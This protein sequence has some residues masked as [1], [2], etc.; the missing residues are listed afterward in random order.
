MGNFDKE[1]E[2]L[3]FQKVNN[4]KLYQEEI[5]KRVEEK[6]EKLKEQRKNSMPDFFIPKSEMNNILEKIIEEEFEKE[7]NFLKS[8]TEKKDNVKEN[9]ENK[10]ENI[11]TNNIF[12]SAEFEKKVKNQREKAEENDKD[13][14]FVNEQFLRFNEKFNNAVEKR[15]VEKIMKKVQPELFEEKG[16]YTLTIVPED[17][18][19][20]SCYYMP[21]QKITGHI[22]LSSDPDEAF[23]QALKVVVENG[24]AS[25]SLLQRKFHIGFSRAAVLIDKM[26]EKGFISSFDGVNPRK[27][28]IDIEGFKNEF[29]ED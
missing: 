5:M 18:K 23:K 13:F 22:E 7:N 1:F 29:G 21:R 19:N 17:D 24:Q 26:E 3:F 27:V 25:I 12:A 9:Q 14:Y 16:N 2:K 4:D 11:D 6:T 15:K 10:A 28:F 8:N 20:S